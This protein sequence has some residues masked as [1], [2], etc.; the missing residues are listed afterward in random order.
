A[1]RQRFAAGG[2]AP[3]VLAR[4]L[5]GE[6]HSAGAVAIEVVLPLL[7]EELDRAE[8][9]RRVATAEGSCNAIVGQLAVEHDGLAAELRGRVRVRVGDQGVAVQRG[10]P[11]VH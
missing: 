10:E 11:P 1:A 2:A 7:R 3:A 8:E 6:T 4:L 5:R 9:A